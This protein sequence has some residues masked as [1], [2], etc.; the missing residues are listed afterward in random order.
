MYNGG[1]GGR[2]V[3][4]LWI[5]ESRWL[6]RGVEA[7]VSSSRSVMTEVGD[8][9]GFVAVL[10]TVGVGEAGRDDDDDAFVIYVFDC[11]L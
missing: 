9:G 5:V 6:E 7:D 1:T 11:V 10:G 4:S 3:G 2:L 8:A